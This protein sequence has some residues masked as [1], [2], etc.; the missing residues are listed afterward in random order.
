MK[1]FLNYAPLRRDS[2]LLGPYPATDEPGTLRHELMG[3]SECE[4]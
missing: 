4:A 1:S 3:R 2:R